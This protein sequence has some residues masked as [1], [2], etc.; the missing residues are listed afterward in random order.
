MKKMKVLVAKWPFFTGV[1]MMAIVS[2]ATMVSH[3]FQFKTLA[4]AVGITAFLVGTCALWLSI[5]GRS[6]AEFNRTYDSHREC[7]V[8][9]VPGHIK[10]LESFSF[11]YSVSFIVVVVPLSFAFF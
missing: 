7:W 5:T 3:H 1:A 11:G 2:T 6:N 9:D 8:T 10:W 4:G